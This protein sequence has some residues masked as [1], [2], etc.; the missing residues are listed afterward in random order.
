MKKKEEFIISKKKISLEIN[1]EE[2]QKE[3]DSIF[4]N[5]EEIRPLRLGIG[6][7]YIPFSQTNELL[8]K[9]LKKKILKNKQQEE[10]I[11]NSQEDDKNMEESE[12]ESKV[13]IFSK[14]KKK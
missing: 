5:I 8:N 1:L 12:E 6:A 11:T 7:K 14:K 9:N 13:T 3:E 10:L 2:I 4:Q